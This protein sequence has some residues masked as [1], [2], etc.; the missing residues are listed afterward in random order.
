MCNDCRVPLESCVLAPQPGAR[1]EGVEQ[2]HDRRE[3]VGRESLEETVGAGSW[4]TGADGEEGVGRE[5]R[6]DGDE[7]PVRWVVE[8]LAA[9]HQGPACATSSSENDWDVGRPGGEG[10]L[11]QDVKPRLER[12]RGDRRVGRGWGGD[13]QGIE[14]PEVELAE[15][16]RE[17]RARGEPG[18][19]RQ[20]AL[21]VVA[22]RRQLDLV[23]REERAEVARTPASRAEERHP[24]RSRG[25]HGT[26]YHVRETVRELLLR[27]FA[28]GRR[29]GRGPTEISLETHRQLDEVER[30]GGRYVGALVHRDVQS[31]V[32]RSVGWHLAPAADEGAEPLREGANRADLRQ[33]CFQLAPTLEVLP[34]L[35]AAEPPTRRRAHLVDRTPLARTVSAGQQHLHA[36]VQQPQASTDG[37]WHVRVELDVGEHRTVAASTA[38]RAE[39]APL[40]LEVGAHER[41]GRAAQ[42]SSLE[43]PD[44]PST[45]LDA[46]LPTTVITKLPDVL[47]RVIDQ[48]A[49]LLNL[50]TGTYCGMNEVATRAWELIDESIT[51]DA[52]ATKLHGEF[53]VEEARLREDLVELV[54]AMEQAKLVA[55][56]SPAP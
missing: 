5:R 23:V 51:F 8:H 44:R 27:F 29:V 34:Q 1:P 35:L 19:G 31:P 39:Q 14:L 20:R 37:R 38:G 45:M 32:R 28:L 26:S 4:T 47:S 25:E 21:V 6:R 24:D 13:D 18:C 22:D 56:T 55:L 12:G 46:M 17:A 3:V 41:L 7:C 11:D 40:A 50:G 42:P 36:L 10:L 30:Q 16:A 2:G 54:R 43:P 48:E 49:V 52:L 15:V 53:D 9:E 33:A